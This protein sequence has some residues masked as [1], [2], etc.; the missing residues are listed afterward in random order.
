VYRTTA[1]AAAWAARRL[2]ARRPHRHARAGRAVPR[3]ARAA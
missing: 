2:A 1:R 3:R